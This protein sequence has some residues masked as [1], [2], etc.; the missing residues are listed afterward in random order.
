MQMQMTSL[1]LE[2]V[3]EILRLSAALNVAFPPSDTP[4]DY[5]N[6]AWREEFRRYMSSPERSALFGYLNHLS[7]DARRELLAL[8]W[9]GRGDAD[10]FPALVRYA[11][12]ISGPSDA[13]YIIEKVHALPLYLREGLRRLV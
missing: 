6:D 2:D 4:L 11:V 3:Q 12:G 10:D 8:M 9:L 5:S 7:M 13:Q 1:R